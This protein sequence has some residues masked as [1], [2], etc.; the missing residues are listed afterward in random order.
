MSKKHISK[1]NSNKS[2]QTLTSAKNKCGLCGSSRKK[3]MKTA[4]CNNWICDDE[5]KYV[6]FS[7]ARNCCARNHRRFTLCCA[8]Y[9]ER[10]KGEWKNCEKCKKMFDPEMYDWYGTNEYNFEKLDELLPFTPVRCG[11]C[12]S[13]ILQSRESYTACP[14]GTYRCELC[15]EVYN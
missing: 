8:H 5:D 14:D 9:D 7:Y 10:H 4:C 6:L 3:L 2:V 15:Q 12:G 11:K 13:M 1:K